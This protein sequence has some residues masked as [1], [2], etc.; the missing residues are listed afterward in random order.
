VTV[1][2]VPAVHVSYGIVGSLALAKA[3]STL[4][5]YTVVGDGL[6]ALHERR[7]LASRGGTHEDRRH[8][9]GR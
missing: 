7:R 1:T 8:N 9:L 6:L 3:E 2:A 5:W 4:E